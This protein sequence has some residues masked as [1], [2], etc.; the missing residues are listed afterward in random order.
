MT[1]KKIKHKKMS[2]LNINKNPNFKNSRNS[3]GKSFFKRR[4]NIKYKS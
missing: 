1:L 2:Y 4:K 3:S